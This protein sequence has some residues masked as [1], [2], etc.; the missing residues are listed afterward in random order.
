MTDE[1]KSL[2]N[3][4]C[5]FNDLVSG[6][7]LDR[8]SILTTLTE[9]GALL[10]EDGHWYL[11]DNPDELDGYL[12]YDRVRNINTKQ[13]QVIN[14]LVSEENRRRHAQQIL[15]DKRPPLIIKAT[16]TQ[17]EATAFLVFSDNH[18][19]EVIERSNTYNLNEH[20]P[21]IAR[22]RMITVAQRAAEELKK[23]ST[24]QTIKRLVLCFLGDHIHGDIHEPYTQVHGNA[25]TVLEE[26]AQVGQVLLS[27]IQFF[28]GY[29]LDVVCV[30]GNH[31]RAT[32]KK[33]ENQNQGYSYEQ[34]MFYNL[35]QQASLLKLD[36]T[37]HIKTERMQFITAYNH[38]IRL[39]HG[40]DITGGNPH[41]SIP[42]YLHRINQIQN[43]RADLTVM[44]HWHQS[45]AS[46]D[47]IINGC[48]CGPNPYSLS[49]G[50]KPEPPKQTLF[51][52]DQG[53][54]NTVRFL[55]A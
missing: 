45:F 29:K 35:E 52:V 44:G 30:P 42:K 54:L 1:L 24:I 48:T 36:C 16:T 4:T 14:K 9:L 20:T 28:K 43:L 15:D 50:F 18:F 46:S 6:T 33:R 23:L 26:T 22:T 55:E 38:R 8:N 47:Y 34:F 21:D 53:G 10:S 5:K 32:L 19:A 17:N 31:G 40:D 39:M 13:Q 25:L 41:T 7:G 12:A 51:L 37:F 3:G 27:I 49:F 2:L 11:P